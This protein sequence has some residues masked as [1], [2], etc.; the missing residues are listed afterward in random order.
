MGHVF[1]RTEAIERLAALQLHSLTAADRRELLLGWWGDD[2]GC[3]SIDET[4]DTRV[5]GIPEALRP[6][7]C[8][9]EWYDHAESPDYDPLLLMALSQQFYG[10]LNSYILQALRERAI[11]VDAISG[12]PEPMFPCPCCGYVAIPR[13]GEYDICP[14]CLW[15]D[16]GLRGTVWSGRMG[17]NHITI[18][19][20]RANFHRYGVCDPARPPRPDP[21]A[22]RKYARGPGIGKACHV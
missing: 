15:E 11:P 20:G 7:L 6:L 1:L 18:E 2:E 17:P 22:R 19:S 10:V 4:V 16:E 9:R 8:G 13:R 5:K 14:V 21:D 12:D 3:E